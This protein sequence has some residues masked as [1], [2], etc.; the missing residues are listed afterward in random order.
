MQTSLHSSYRRPSACRAFPRVFSAGVAGRALLR[1][2]LAALAGV[3]GAGAR[4]DIIPPGCSG[5]GYG[6]SLFVDKPVTRVGD[7]LS[8]TLLL[9]NQ[10]FPACQAEMIAANIITPDGVT[11]P[12]EV[13]RRTLDPGQSDLYRDVVSYVV[14]QQDITNQVVKAAATSTAQINQSIQ[15]IRSDNYR[16]VSTPVVNSCIDVTATCAGGVGETGTITFNGAVRNCGSIPLNNVTVVN[17]LTGGTVLG[18]ISL[19]PGEQQAFSG[20]FVPPNPCA[21]ATATLTAQGQD[22]IEPIRTLTDS[23]QVTCQNTLSPAVALSAECGVQPAAPGQP[24]AY[25]GVVRNTGNVT[26]TNLVIVANQ[27]AANT[28][29]QTI[30]RLAPGEAANFTGSYPA[31]PACSSTVNLTV[32]GRSLCNVAVNANASITCPVQSN[33]AI[34]ITSACPTTPPA[35]GGRLDYSGTVRNTGDVALRN[36]RVFSQRDPDSPIFTVSSLAPGAS[37]NFTGRFTTPTG[38][39]SVTD[40]LTVT[41]EN[42]CGG[43]NVTNLVTRTCPLQTSPAIQVTTQ[44]PGTQAVAGGSLT[45]SG[46]VRNTGNIALR[47]VTV[48]ADQPV[49]NTVIFTLESLE[50]GASANFNGTFPVAVDTCSVTYNLRASGRGLC[51]ETD[52]TATDGSTCTIT[53]TAGIEITSQCPAAPASAGGTLTY[54]GRVRNTGTVALTNIQVTSDRAPGN[55]VVFTIESLAPGAVADFTGSFTA[56]ADACEVTDTLNVSARN[57]CTNASVSARTT[58]TCPLT[59]GGTVD[60]VVN[61]PSS[62]GVPGQNLTYSG[63]VRNS[64]TVTLNNIQVIND[65][66]P[67]APVHQVNSLSPGK[68]ANFTAQVRVPTNVCTVA[69]TFSVTATD[70]CGSGVVRDTAA[71]SCPVSTTPAIAVTHECPTETPTPGATATLTGT[72][73][74]TGNVT[75]TEVAVVSSG[76]TVLGPVTLEPGQLANFTASFVPPSDTCSVNASITASGRDLCSERTVTSTST[77]TCTVRTSP[78][79]DL[80]M[81]CPPAPVGGGAPLVYSGSVRN[82]GD[83]TLT[84]VVVNRAGNRVFGPVTLAPGVATNFT[85]QVSAPAGA[86]SVTESW[87][88]SARDRCTTAQVTDTASTTCP[89]LTTPGVA[90]TIACPAGALTP[91]G[92]A[93]YSGT[94]RNTG[95]VTLTDLVVANVAAPGTPVFQAATLAPGATASFTAEVAVGR[96]ICSLT[97]G[98]IVSAGNLCSAMRVTEGA[99]ATCPVSTSPQLAV[100]HACPPAP[101]APG[102]QATFAGSVRNAGNVTLEG[103]TVTSSLAGQPPVFG[104]VTLAPGQVAEFTGSYTIPTDTTTCTYRHTLNASG[105]DKCT[106]ASVAATSSTDC[107]IAYTPSVII[108]SACPEQ[109]VAPGQPLTY[110][111]SVQNTGN[112]ALRNVRI[113]DSRSGDQTVFSTDSLPAGESRTFTGTFTVPNDCCS[114]THTLTVTAEDICASIAVRDTSTATCPVLYQPALTLTRQCPPSPVEPGDTRSFSGSVGNTGNVTLVDVFVRAFVQGQS[115]TVIGPI[116][117]APG[118]TVNFQGSYVVPTDFCGADE[119]VATGYDLCEGRTTTARVTTPCPVLTSP[120]IAV[121]KHCPTTPVPKNGTFAYSGTVFNIGNVTLTNVT[122][123]NNLPA[124]GT[125]VFG[126]VTLAPGASMNFTGSYPIDAKCC[127]VVDTLT[128]RGQDVCS[129]E[130][131]QNTATA[132]CDVLYAPALQISK[133]C[134]GGNRFTGVVRNTGN[135]VLTNV[136]VS[137]GLGSEAVRLLGPFE[138]AIG[139]TADFGGTAATDVVVSA[140]AEPVCGE[141]RVV[142]ASTCAGPVTAEPDI[143]DV[144]VEDGVLVLRWTAIPGRTYR[145]QYSAAVAPATWQDLPGDVTASSAIA[146]KT[147]ALGSN[148]TRFYRVLLLP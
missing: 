94:V 101:G 61:C 23:V 140:T 148:L 95:D 128:A 85:T 82:T 107:P 49:A 122:V 27:P 29:V 2:C 10:E 55:R 92:T 72:V 83:V 86:C 56:P 4:A 44:C 3:W 145:V 40:T 9:S 57:R 76:S 125:P 58:R 66:A 93:I 133:Q 37:A 99:S 111:A 137:T 69:A 21:P 35:P 48:V 47:N 68:S 70:R 115:L 144:H 117:L 123:V 41:A 84:E 5:N 103:V 106:R 6:I 71:V 141:D 28:S 45:Y 73:R 53:T 136:I 142:V 135:I 109:A 38:V 51:S 116:A 79:V 12:I 78:G 17:S 43:P 127:W 31:P 36:V 119:V 126:P 15:G 88:T 87:A 132:V 81:N 59:V 134:L 24:L 32:N 1:L 13:R 46:T 105:T 80:T 124:A 97:T 42:T 113:V 7:T 118:Q 120:M 74:N 50:A 19:A 30:A 112:V 64:G 146:F 91:G 143:T 139:E 60:L 54:T 11:H 18:P 110:T 130:A 22:N 104:P 75:L 33:P 20:S 77:R 131:V 16:D 34:S 121:V 108:L 100:T 52:V 8:Y 25:S 14:R 62:P 67:D 26:L 96:D 138:L 102:A 63:T 90:L 114:V 129:G 147:D 98:F 39:C 65:A 89:L